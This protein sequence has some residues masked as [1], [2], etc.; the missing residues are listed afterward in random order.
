MS[1]KKPAVSLMM[2]ALPVFICFATGAVP[3][4]NSAGKEIFS[5]GVAIRNA[6]AGE[7][8]RANPGSKFSSC[9]VALTS[10][11]R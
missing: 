6:H 8:V 3:Q 4:A 7:I 2:L 10:R 1:I 11:H 5:L 9:P